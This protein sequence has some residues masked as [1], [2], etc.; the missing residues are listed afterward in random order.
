M[1]LGSAIYLWNG[2][3]GAIDQLMEAGMDER[4]TSLSWIEDGTHMAVGTS[5]HKVQIFDVEKHKLM[6]SMDGHSARVSSLSWNG[7]HVS[8]GGP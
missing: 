2:S 8:S 3:N 7:P 5:D 1:A 4:V 6:R